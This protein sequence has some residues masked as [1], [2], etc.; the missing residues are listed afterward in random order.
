MLLRVLIVFS[1]L[2]L[3]LCQQLSVGTA[4]GAHD[5]ALGG[6]VTPAWSYSEH[7][8]RDP[9]DAYS[10]FFYVSTPKGVADFTFTKNTTHVSTA[11]TSV[12]DVKG[13]SFVTRLGVQFTCKTS[14]TIVAN[15]TFMPQGTSPMSFFWEKEC[16]T[17]PVWYFLC[18]PGN[19]CM[20]AI[21][22]FLVSWGAI[23]TDSP[24]IHRVQQAAGGQQEI[25]WVGAIA[26]VVIAS[27]SLL[28]IFFFLKQMAVLLT[29]CISFAA[30]VAV[31]MLVYSLVEG[32]AR[33]TCAN[34][35]LLQTWTIPYCGDFTNLE[36]AS[37]F[38]GLTVVLV[39]FFTR[40]WIPN[41][42]IGA[43]LCLYMMSM[44]QLS[45]IKVAALLLTLLFFYDIFW[46]FYSSRFFGQSVM[47]AAATGLDLPIK[48]ILPRVLTPCLASNRTMLGLGD[49]ALPGLLISFT[50][51][52]DTYIHNKTRVPGYFHICATGY[53]VGMCMCFVVLFVFRSAQPALLYLV[54]C[55][56]IPIL[57]AGSIHGEVGALWHGISQRMDP[58]PD[59]AAVG[60]EEEAA[61]LVD[62]EAGLATRPGQ[63]E[64][65]GDELLAPLEE[66]PTPYHPEIRMGDAKST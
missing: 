40:H 10:K 59:A 50:R 9:C 32:H 23:R 21:A 4:E 31:T 64:G 15:V 8:V 36:L 38:A 2:A 1:L 55:T 53:A 30:T 29:I 45:S 49:I 52:F 58:N 54:P 61:G 5:V 48:L 47:V 56:L 12:G 13:Y 20:I 44:L 62:E 27:I 7:S 65:E 46:V 66:V 35:P 63:S 41:D 25:S 16:V 34:T 17:Y 51:R 26:F 24:F 6:V 39:W 28:L 11:D 33:R 37:L 60:V 3:G 42:I 57:I 22:V 43:S 18:D 19:V 14:G